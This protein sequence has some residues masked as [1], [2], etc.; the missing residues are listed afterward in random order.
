LAGRVQVVAQG[1]QQFSAVGGVVVG[2]SA[3]LPFGVVLDPG[4]YAEC[5]EE[6][7]QADVGLARGESVPQGVA[8][9]VR[10]LRRLGIASRKERA[11]PG[12]S[13]ASLPRHRG[14]A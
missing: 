8:A 2:E 3:E 12:R 11:T 6:T 14:R 4:V 9:W 5:E 13:V 7:A 10:S 1:G